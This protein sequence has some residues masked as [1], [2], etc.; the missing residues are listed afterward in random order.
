MIDLDSLWS[1][2]VFAEHRNFTRASELL[3]ISQPALH[4]KIRK[5]AD[6]LRVPLYRK[7]GRR[8]ELTEQGKK[9]AAFGR[10]MRDRSDGFVQALVSGEADQPVVLA[11][12]EGAFLYLLGPAL[13]RFSQVCKIP[14]R[15]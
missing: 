1:F 11:A 4:V 7:I 9:V 13:R 10:E 8:L 5:L 6:A 2:A 14:P 12:G 3:H 15:L